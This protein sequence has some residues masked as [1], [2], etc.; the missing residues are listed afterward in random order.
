LNTNAGA[1]IANPGLWEIFFGQN[2]GQNTTLGDPNTLYFAAGISG[3]K[4]GLFGS[5]AVAQQ[6]A[7]NFTFQA[8]ANSV[9]VAAGQTTRSLTL[10]LAATNGS[11]AR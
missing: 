6:A 8:S 11:M 1:P 7:A 9:T 5:I 2:G 3:E 10:S 4:G